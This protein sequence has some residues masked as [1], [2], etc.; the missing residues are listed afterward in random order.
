MRHPLPH[1]LPACRALYR[2]RLPADNPHPGSAA[3]A[4]A[5]AP[6]SPAAA[7]YRPVLG[8]GSEDPMALLLE[9]AASAAAGRMQPDAAAAAGPG[10]PA[11]AAAAPGML[12]APHSGGTAAAT[13]LPGVDAEPETPAAERPRS[14][15]LLASP[16]PA[17]G[18]SP[19]LQPAGA[20]HFPAA[21]QAGGSCPPQGPPPP[22]SRSPATLALR[23]EQPEAGEWQP[24]ASPV[25]Y[26]SSEGVEVPLNPGC[27][28]PA[29]LAQH[30][31]LAG[32]QPA[33]ATAGAPDGQR[34][35]CAPGTGRLRE[36]EG[37]LPHGGGLVAAA[38][39]PPVE[40]A[41]GGGDDL[42][43]VGALLAGL[44]EEVEGLDPA[45]GR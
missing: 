45:A 30:G 7:G 12:A 27:L 2:E 13:S 38:A 5:A 9:A 23:R 15:A 41:G 10:A 20:A 28:R 14:A 44:R 6:R 25:S 31:G 19:A 8:C 32:L 21:A 4:A 29:V 24:G 26:D 22:P 43:D 39:P 17:G 42:S 36:E 40:P 18:H 16:G 37:G 3:A 1:R 33:E 11:Q 35:L 34:T